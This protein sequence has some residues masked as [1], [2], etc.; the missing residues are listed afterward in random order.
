MN[1]NLE[2]VKAKIQRYHWLLQTNLTKA[3]RK[4]VAEMLGEQKRELKKQERELKKQK[5]LSGRSLARRL[6]RALPF[7][8]R[9]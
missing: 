9:S 1:E 2:T 6:L 4:L 5:R 3:R 7:G 8:R